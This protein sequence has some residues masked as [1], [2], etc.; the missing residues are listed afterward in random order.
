MPP[1]GKIPPGRGE[2]SGV[3][4]WVLILVAGVAVALVL[5]GTSVFADVRSVPD[6]A[7]DALDAGGGRGE[8]RAQIS[9]TEFVRVPRG[10]TVAK[11]R[12][13]LGEPE[14][15]AKATVEGR[16]VECWLYGIAGATGAFQLCFDNGKLSSRF[17]YG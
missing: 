1:V 11:A 2:R 13:L 6:R 16:T 14:S 15:T 4:R 7:R 5:S 10:A 9:P 17:R 8:S 3:V 12:G